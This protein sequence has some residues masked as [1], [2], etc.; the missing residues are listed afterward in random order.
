MKNPW[1][2]EQTGASHPPAQSAQSSSPHNPI[3]P[4]TQ[5]ISNLIIRITLIIFKSSWFQQSSQVRSLSASSLSVIWEGKDKDWRLNIHSWVKII[6]CASRKLLAERETQSCKDWIMKTDWC[7]YDK[8]NKEGDNTRWEEFV[9]FFSMSRTYLHNF[10]ERV[11]K[12][13]IVVTAC[14]TDSWL[15]DP[16]CSNCWLTDPKWARSCCQE[17]KLM[18]S[19]GHLGFA[20]DCHLSRLGPTQLQNVLYK[21]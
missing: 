11:S 3:T 8:L 18:G 19:Q 6:G 14:D 2:E 21:I 17:V 5:V 7:E 4:L 12:L 20:L 10:F 1:K 9:C 16:I 13:M 15:I